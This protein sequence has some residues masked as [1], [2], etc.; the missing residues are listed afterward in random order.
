M[1]AFVL[2]A[3]PPTD[4]IGGWVVQ[5]MDTLGAP[6][7]G[8]LVGL[9]SVFPPLPSELVLP[10]AGFTASLG[11]LSLVAAIVWATVGSVVGAWVL[12]GLGAVLGRDRVERLLDKVPLVDVE[13]MLKAE[14]FFVRHGTSAVLVGRVIPGVRSLVSIPAGLERM[15]I[16]RFSLLT[17]G[18]SLVWNAALI[19]AGYYLGE[20]YA[21]VQQY[22]SYIQYAVFALVAALL[23]WYVVKRV[24]RHRERGGDDARSGSR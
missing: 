19:L 12:Y 16:L 18:G 3:A 5:V 8:V 6:G 10:M 11:S 2:A 9:E 23:G 21:V 17:G 4:G 14:D 24:R 13:D 20:E 7:V 22:T 15:P 1:P